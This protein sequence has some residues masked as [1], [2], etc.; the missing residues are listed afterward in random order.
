MNVE[1]HTFQ[2]MSVNYSE[3]LRKGIWNRNY[4]FP[5]GDDLAEA[6]QCVW[7]VETWLRH[8]TPKERSICKQLK[9]YT[10]R[11]EGDRDLG[12]S[13]GLENTYGFWKG[14]LHICGYLFQIKALY[15][16]ARN[17]MGTLVELNG[18]IILISL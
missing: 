10:E 17:T 12:Y 18:K 11:F 15:E 4:V 9:W 1:I 5:L 8:S 3:C 16:H 7:S 14:N 13:E 2:G 6:A